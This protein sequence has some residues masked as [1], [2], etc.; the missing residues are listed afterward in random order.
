MRKASFAVVVV[1]IIALFGARISAQQPPPASG[2]Q[3]IDA[4]D[5]PVA[6][7]EKRI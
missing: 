5:R 6:G 1:T 7:N 2:S 3:F 4:Y